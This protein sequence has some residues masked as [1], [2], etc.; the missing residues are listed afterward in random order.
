MA[1]FPNL[2][3]PF[4]KGEVQATL[5]LYEAKWPTKTS[6]YSILLWWFFKNDIAQGQTTLSHGQ[7]IA[8][9]NRILETDQ[10][11]IT[12]ILDLLADKWTSFEAYAGT[13]TFLT[14]IR[15]SLL[16]FP[17]PSQ[18]G[19]LPLSHRHFSSEAIVF[20]N[21]YLKR[22]AQVTIRQRGRI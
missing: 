6:A 15:S 9:S 12:G 7:Y 21:E 13:K 1:F 11:L 5:E 4:S 8:L 2:L 14:F 18:D 17:N 3:A 19:R 10:T 22:N 20:L 16:Q